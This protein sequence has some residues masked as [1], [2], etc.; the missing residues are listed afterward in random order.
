MY[1]YSKH[2]IAVCHTS[3]PIYIRVTFC[4]ETSGKNTCLGP[5]LLSADREY[6]K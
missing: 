3:P 2:G 1:A 4:A 6:T 5:Q